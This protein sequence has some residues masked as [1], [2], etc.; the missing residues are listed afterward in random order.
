MPGAAKVNPRAAAA[1]AFL[2]SARAAGHKPP[3]RHLP[4]QQPP[5]ALA[6]EY[7]R[8]MRGLVEGA[9]REAYAPL[10]R[11]LPTMLEDARRARGDAAEPGLVAQIVARLTGRPIATRHDDRTKDEIAAAKATMGQQVDELAIARAARKAGQQAADLNR[12]QLG[13]QVQAVAGFDLV[14]DVPPAVIDGFIAENVALIQDITP[15]LAARI[16]AAIRRALATG[17]V[18]EDLAQVIN[19][20]MVFAASRAELIAIDQVH[21]VY[22]QVNERRQADLGVTEFIWRNVGDE[23]VAGNPGGLYPN[24]KPSHWD[25]GGKKYQWS[26]PP[27]NEKGEPDPPGRR[28]RCRCSAEPVLDH[29]LDDLPDLGPEATG[30]IERGAIT[31]PSPPPSPPPPVDLAALTRAAEAAHRQAREQ[32]AAARAQRE[33]QVA[34][35]RA[36]WEAA[37]AAKLAAQRPG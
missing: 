24:A 16:E 6:L 25:R 19:Q 23:R 35:E 7:A 5:D 15:A 29:L 2:R 34:A 28:P 9:I 1:V 30:L 36:A 17:Q 11:T 14:G 3:R 22:A 27:K 31:F 21:K 10:L 4:R 37:R 12:R 26:D 33:S 20:H 32:L 13:A 18:H 8:T